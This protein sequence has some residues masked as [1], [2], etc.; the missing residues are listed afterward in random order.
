[1]QPVPPISSYREYEASLPYVQQKNF[2]PNLVRRVAVLRREG[3]A[4]QAACKLAGLLR[5]YGTSKAYVRM[6]D[7]L[8]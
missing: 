8:K 4:L 3:Y 6:P 5:N 1:M 2:N 7:H